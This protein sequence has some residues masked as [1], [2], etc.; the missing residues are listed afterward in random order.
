[1]ARPRKNVKRVYRP[2][3]RWVQSRVWSYD[4]EVYEQTSS[5]QTCLFCYSTFGYD[6]N[7]KFMIRN[8]F[9]TG[10]QNQ[11][12]YKKWLL[13]GRFFKLFEESLNKNEDA[14]NVDGRAI[15]QFANVIYMSLRFEKNRE[16]LIESIKSIA[17]LSH[18][19]TPLELSELL[20]QYD[21]ILEAKKKRRLAK[22]RK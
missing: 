15:L 7:R 3:H 13:V 22:R 11:M 2:A 1:M 8:K 19:G 20:E 10:C 4:D 14:A 16:Y 9:C 5:I 18:L 21:E 12:A 17:N 6:F